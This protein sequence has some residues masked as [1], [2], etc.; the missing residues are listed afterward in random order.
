MGLCRNQRQQDFLYLQQQFL[1]IAV[2]GI[3]NPVGADYD[4]TP[5]EVP[6][7]RSQFPDKLNLMVNLANDAI[8]YIIPKSEWDEDAPR[9]IFIPFTF[10]NDITNSIVC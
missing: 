3:E 2:G 10:W 1:E 5:Q 9:G 8:G 4:I 6:H 7:L